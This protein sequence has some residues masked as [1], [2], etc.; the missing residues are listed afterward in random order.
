M[1]AAGQPHQDR[2]WERLED[3]WGTDVAPYENL[4]QSSNDPL[5]Q[6]PNSDEFLNIFNGMAS[7]SSQLPGE[8][9]HY[10][11]MI[12][13]P[14]ATATADHRAAQQPPALPDPSYPSTETPYMVDGHTYQ[15]F[16]YDGA[17][18]GHLANE[19]ASRPIF[20]GPVVDRVGW[21]PNFH[22][23]VHFFDQY[24]PSDKWGQTESCILPPT[25]A[26]PPP[27]A[28]HVSPFRA[29]PWSPY[30][31][32]IP[33]EQTLPELE[34]LDACMPEIQ[35]GN[36]LERNGCALHSYSGN[37][38]GS[39][40]LIEPPI[41]PRASMTSIDDRCSAAIPLLEAE[42]LFVCPHGLRS[43]LMPPEV[44]QPAQDIFKNRLRTTEGGHEKAEPSN[45]L[46]Q[47]TSDIDDVS[48]IGD[49]E[50]EVRSRNN[51]L[52]SAGHRGRRGMGSRAS[53]AA[54][55]IDSLQ[56]ELC[57]S[58]FR[59]KHRKGSLARHIRI[60]HGSDEGKAKEFI[61]R[62]CECRSIFKRKDS[63]LKHE[64]TH[65]PELDHKAAVS[66]PQSWKSGRH[67]N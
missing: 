60:Q 64:R 17:A 54:L 22:Q 2:R 31:T 66:R 48:S 24:Q 13:D 9:G 41:T 45:N 39:P 36:H 1:S 67:R 18:Q 57:N 28:A 3:K 16:R 5:M 12:A 26:V 52:L 7:H 55:S 51:S 59:G 30:N 38:S 27:P 56:C 35:N 23:Q 34:R 62:G 40:V 61:C 10:T 6:G 15:D 19:Q 50:S 37:S 47:S 11:L 42:N 25:V 4:M 53:S 33:L 44:Y 32:R 49:E 21:G 58:Q 43:G 65:H 8:Q 63:R 29:E 46:S 14:E 20:E